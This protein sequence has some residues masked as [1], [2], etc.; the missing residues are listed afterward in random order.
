MLGRAVLAILVVS[1]LAGPASAQDKPEKLEW[2]FKEGQKFYLEQ[3]VDNDTTITVLGMKQAEKQNTQI[4]LSYVVKSAG[5]DGFV[6][7]QR[8]EAWRFKSSKDGPG[9]EEVVSKLLESIFKDVVF[10]VRISKSG[11]L[12]GLDGYEQMMKNAAKVA[13]TPQ[14]LEQ[15]KGLVSLDVLRSWVIL[16]FDVLS[17][18]AVAKGDQWSKN[19]EVAIPALGTITTATTYTLEDKGKG[20]AVIGIKDTYDIRPGKN[21]IAPGVKLVKVAL[22][23]K[24]GTGKLVFDADKGRLV[25]VDRTVP[26]AGSMTFSAQGMMIDADMESNETRA[27]RWHDQRPKV[28]DF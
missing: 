16:N 17:D 13:T 25:S 20:G 11:K 26:L 14:E 15:F 4:V 9:N 19:L 12:L 7:E 3:R 23:K 6:L 21:D 1:T 24:E 27:T 5:P 22:A 28:E 10:T 18:K 8:V 2:R